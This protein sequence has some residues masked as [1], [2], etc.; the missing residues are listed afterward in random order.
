MIEII[1]SHAFS[2]FCGIDSSNQVPN[3][4][5]IGRFRNLLA[6]NKWQEKLFIRVLSILKDRKL[7]LKKDQ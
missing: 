6:A 4:D 7:I 2:E 3:G 1:D 5:T